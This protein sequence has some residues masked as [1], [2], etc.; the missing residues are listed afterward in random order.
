M[1]TVQAATTRH[2]HTESLSGIIYDQYLPFTILTYLGGTVGRVKWAEKFKQG[3]GRQAKYDFASNCKQVK[4][5]YE[6]RGAS[7]GCLG[8]TQGRQQEAAGQHC[9][10]FNFA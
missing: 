9:F 3:N 7:A 6:S 4:C 1:A 8:A 5:I 2:C 10:Y